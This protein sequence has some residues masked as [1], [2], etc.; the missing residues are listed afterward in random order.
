MEKYRNEKNTQQD[1]YL[2][3][4]EYYSAMKSISSSVSSFNISPYEQVNIN[5][6]QQLMESCFAISAK[7]RILDLIP[8]TENSSEIFD[9]SIS[10]D[11]T[12]RGRIRS[13]I[14]IIKSEIEGSDVSESLK[15]KILKKLNIFLLELDKTRTSLESF[16]EAFLSCTYALCVGYENLSK[17]ITLFRKIIGGLS[18]IHSLEHN[19][20][21]S[22]EEMKLLPPP[23]SLNEDYQ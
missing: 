2:F 9:A 7:V 19:I 6:P 8:L 18:K 10:L 12:W 22:P 1:K 5:D 3:L 14:D 4:I 21:P 17:P 15:Q 20:L 23:D 11:E 16:N 13:Y